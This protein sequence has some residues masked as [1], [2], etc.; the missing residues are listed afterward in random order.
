[1]TNKITHKFIDITPDIAG[2]WL[3]QN[4]A[5]YRHCD[6]NRVRL[7]A[8]QMKSGAWDVNG[9]SIKFDQ[10]GCLIDGQHRLNAI[11]ESGTTQSMLVLTNVPSDINIDTGKP[12]VLA[13]V[14]RRAGLKSGVFLATIHRQ[15]QCIENA[16]NGLTF[17]CDR[18]AI[19]TAMREITR[20]KEVYYWAHSKAKSSHDAFCATR[21]GA[22]LLVFHDHDPIKAQEFADLCC[23]SDLLRSDHPVVV[24]ISTITNQIIRGKRRPAC[25]WECA[26][27]VKAWN[28]FL[29]NR[30]SK[31]LRYNM[32][33]AQDHDFPEIL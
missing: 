29:S 5:N 25:E 23:K 19:E 12:R 31:T 17:R 22:C 30:T 10:K 18:P 6:A 24:A 32:G 14:L 20:N 21:F 9:E 15:K 7:Y 8:K 2:E 4:S 28:L 11:V 26:I 13:D 1:M 3:L 33:G 27:T 16:A